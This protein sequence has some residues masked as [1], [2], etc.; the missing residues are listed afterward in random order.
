MRRDVTATTVLLAA[1]LAAACLGPARAAA[2]RK[3]VHLRVMSYNIHVGVGMDKK[4][5]LKRIADVIKLQRCDL[6]GLQEVD[7]GVERT[8]RVDEIK[9]LARL[10]GMDYAFA[11]NLDYQGGQYGVAV[12]SRYPILAVDHRRYANVRERERRGFIRVEVEVKG[13]RLGFV[14]THLD[15]QFA[16]GRLFETRQLLDAL[17]DVRGPLIVTGDFNEEPEGAAYGLM[18][19]AGFADGWLRG[20]GARATSPGEGATYPADKP[21]KRIDYV[22]Y[23]GVGADHPPHDDE[24]ASAAVPDTLASDHRPVVVSLR[25]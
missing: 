20:R 2:P 23:R 18:R 13:R 21:R 22:F 19:E 5:D 25:F 16:D 11:H 1:L 3:R 10:T 14:T 12:L 24:D 9:E 15:Y 4:L 7:R 6:V 17:K 8:G